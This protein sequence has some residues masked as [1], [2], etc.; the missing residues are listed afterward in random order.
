MNIKLE[1]LK[2]EI[3]ELVM[4]RLNELDIDADKVTDTTAICIL[5]QIQKIIKSDLEDFEKVEDIA[6]VFER[7]NLSCGGCHDFC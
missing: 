3:S 2:N 6:A 4:N 1:L 7:Y 5:S